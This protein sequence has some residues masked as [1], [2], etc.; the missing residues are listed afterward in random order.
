MFS[1]KRFSVKDDR[2]AMKVGADSVLFGA[3]M[4]VSGARRLLDAGCGSGLLALMAAQRLCGDGPAGSSCAPVSN[5]NSGESGRRGDEADFHIDAIDI[6]EGAVADAADNF[7]ASP[8]SEH[9]KARQISLQDYADEAVGVS[10]DFS[11]PA[12]P[13]HS[14]GSPSDR[15]YDLIFCNPPYYDDS[16]TSGSVARDAARSTDTL[17][18]RDLLFAAAKLLTDRGRLSLI[19]PFDQGKKMILEATLFGW[20][21]H[22]QCFVKTKQ[23]ALPKRL[24][25][26]FSPSP[27]TGIK[28]ETLVI[29]DERYSDLTGPFY[30]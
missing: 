15:L 4:D 10:S 12:D 16:P 22:R 2:C 30:L 27:S 23:G 29:G 13:S 18:R 24:M 17:S 6:D 11:F 14:P 1:F 21:L 9:L 7:A 5:G 26:E 25:L 19:L 20:F 28:T 8:W 3:W